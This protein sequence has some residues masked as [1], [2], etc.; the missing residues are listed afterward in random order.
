MPRSADRHDPSPDAPRA[1]GTVPGA[2]QS[3]RL[4]GWAAE[5][6]VAPSFT[7]SET[8]G[9]SC[10]RPCSAFLGHILGE[11]QLCAS[12]SANR[13]GDSC[14]GFLADLLVESLACLVVREHPAPPGGG[15]ALR[16]TDTPSFGSFVK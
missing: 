13:F 12:S 15:G 2:V 10:R 3:P 5:K 4:A 9:A 7:R 14:V 8:L 11:M 16:Q 1:V 6:Q